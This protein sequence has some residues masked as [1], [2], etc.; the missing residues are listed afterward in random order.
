MT[1]TKPRIIVIGGPTASGKTA[2]GIE[3]A[4]S[5]GGQI[6]SADSVQ[7]YRY[8]D[9]GS[10]KPTRAER[11][12]VAH[13]MIDIRN[14][15][16]DFS[17]GDYVREARKCISEIR[18]EGGLPLIVGGTGLY[19]RSLIGGI[20]E[21]PP[22]Q[23]GLRKELRGQEEKGGKGTLFKK[24]AELDPVSA[25]R[26]PSENIARVIRALEV[27]GLTGKRLSEIQEEHSF[28][29]RPYEVLFICLDPNR[30]LLYERIDK[31]VDSMIRGGLLE[32]V[33]Q[34]CGRGYSRELKSMQSLGYRHAGLVLAGQM[35][36]VGATRL[37][38]RDTRHYAKRQLTWFR[39]EPGVSWC[40]PDDLKG[41]GLKVSNFLGD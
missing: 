27:I 7:I 5:R 37:M 25:G 36:L 2:V 22:A 12:R 21:L 39:S 15:D 10:A 23:P 33:F 13:H 11:S 4:E 18:Q 9:V 8:M 3:L 41:I 14:P 35:D 24:L 34:L 30:Q 38:K 1:D 29:D 19:I 26:T 6:V 16:E 28:R 17:A 20:A 40:D 31:R 32:E